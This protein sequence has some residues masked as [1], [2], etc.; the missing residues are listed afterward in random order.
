MSTCEFFFIVIYKQMSKTSKSVS[1]PVY[2]EEAGVECSPSTIAKT[3]GGCIATLLS[4]AAI[5]ACGIIAGGAFWTAYSMAKIADNEAFLS[6]K[7]C[8]LSTESS[9]SFKLCPGQD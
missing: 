1:V 8:R 5:A 9:S 2:N 7:Q 4:F 3:C 6:L